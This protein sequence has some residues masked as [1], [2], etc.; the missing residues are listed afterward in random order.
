MPRR[1][2]RRRRSARLQGRTRPGP[3]Q[4]F[5]AAAGCGRGPALSPLRLRDRRVSRGVRCPVRERVLQSRSG[6]DQGP[7]VARSRRPPEAR[8]QQSGE[9]PFQPRRTLPRTQ[10][11]DRGLSRQG[12]AGRRRRGQ[13]VDRT[14]GNP[15]VPAGGRRRPTSPALPRRQHVGRHPARARRAGGAV[16][17]FRNRRR[18]AAARRYR[19]ARYRPAPRRRRS[20]RRRSAGCG[21]TGA[22]PGHEPQP[23]SAGQ[24]RDRRRLDHR[25][26]PGA[27]R[28]P[29]RSTTPDARRF[30]NTCTPPAN[31]SRWTSSIRTPPPGNCRRVKSTCS[32]GGAKHEK[33]RDDRGGPRRSRGRP[34]PASPHRPAPGAGHRTRSSP[35]DPHSPQQ[36]RVP[37]P[38]IWTGRGPPPPSTN[39]CGT[40][41]SCSR[42][43]HEAGDPRR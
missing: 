15:G 11:E 39:W 17:G 2:Q 18:G 4:H 30:R 31:C 12:G 32:V 29:H 1:A 26:R 24:R 14:K 42:P 19:G 23:G 43:R 3:K 34:D 22:D 37:L 6:R 7:S 35:T 41:A 10:E 5:H 8:R 13:A 40:C 25:R 9:R 20:P 36:G 16:P 33:D 21:R 38:S 28:D 27:R